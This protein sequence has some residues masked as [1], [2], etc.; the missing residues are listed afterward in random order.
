MAALDDPLARAAV[1]AERALLNALEGGCSAP[2]G[3]LAEVVEGEDGDELWMRAVAL[4]TDG[5]LVVR[6]SITGLP[7]R[8]DEVGRTLAAEML[9]DGAGNLEAPE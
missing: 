7:A 2:I 5:G 4:S 3:A 6:R 8:A 1:T 9:E